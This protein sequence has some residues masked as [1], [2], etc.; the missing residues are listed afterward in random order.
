MAYDICDDRADVDFAQLIIGDGMSDNKRIIIIDGNSL[1]NRAYYAIRNP[2]MTKHG[3]YTHAVY[4]FINILNKIINEYD[5]AYML[6]AFDMK[7]PTFR[8]KQYEEYKAGRKKMP[9]F[10]K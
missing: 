3:V 6:I 4:G 2:M 8:H 5:P 1:V 10:K 7:A 9:P